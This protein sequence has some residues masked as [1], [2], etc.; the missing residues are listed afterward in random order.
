LLYGYY[1]I[2]DDL[3]LNNLAISLSFIYSVNY[4]VIKLQ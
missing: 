4:K 1:Y 2:D 3:R